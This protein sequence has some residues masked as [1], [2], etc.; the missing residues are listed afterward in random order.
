MM[1][2]FRVWRGCSN[3]T[4]GIAADCILLVDPKTAASVGLEP[5]L[6]AR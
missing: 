6:L 4:H 1:S 3:P 2:M 5:N